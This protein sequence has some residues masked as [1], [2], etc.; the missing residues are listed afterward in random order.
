MLS[1]AF[2]GLNCQMIL[3]YR[4]FSLNR[5]ARTGYNISLITQFG[6]TYYYK[7]SR[8]SKERGKRII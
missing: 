5:L 8:I 4:L 7:Q 1:A 2:T 6:T 3:E